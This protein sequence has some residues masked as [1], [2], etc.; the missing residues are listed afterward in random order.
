MGIDNLAYLFF[1]VELEMKITD[2]FDL[3]NVM[4]KIGACRNAGDPVGYIAC[5]PYYDAPYED[6]PIC[7]VYEDVIESDG[8][9]VPVKLEI[10]EALARDAIQKVIDRT[11]VKVKSDIGWKLCVSVF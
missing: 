1:G 4:E 5:H 8:N 11:G 6:G 10:N 2:D 3:D 9:L 7:L